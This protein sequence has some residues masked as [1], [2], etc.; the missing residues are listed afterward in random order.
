MRAA[1]AGAALLSLPASARA[2]QI[3]LVC[4]FTEGSHGGNYAADVNQ[5][6]IDKEKVEMD[7]RAAETIGSQQEVNY[8]FRNKGSDRVLFFEGT[9]EHL[10]ATAIRFGTPHSITIDFKAGDVIWTYIDGTKVEYS[11]FRCKR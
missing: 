3:T 8:R 1:L 6:I 2:E 11:K 9:S 4:S 10:S 5:I 7:F